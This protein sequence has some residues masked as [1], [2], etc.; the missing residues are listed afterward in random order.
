MITKVYIPLFKGIFLSLCCAVFF[1][2]GIKFFLYIY[3]FWPYSLKWLFFVNI[4]IIF[5][6]S[7]KFSCVAPSCATDEDTDDVDTNNAIDI[8]YQYRGIN[9]FDL[10]LLIIFVVIIAWAIPALIINWFTGAENSKKF[11]NISV[12]ILCVI[13]SIIYERLNPKQFPALVDKITFYGFA[14]L[15]P[16]S[17]IDY[18]W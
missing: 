2:Y 13:S 9:A 4:L 10:F 16:V 17:L 12:I 1:F 5:F 3:S 11:I 18:L 14:W 6:I 7:I 8:S 15:L